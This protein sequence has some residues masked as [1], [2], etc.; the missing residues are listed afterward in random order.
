MPTIDKLYP[1]TKPADDPYTS[2]WLQE[3]IDEFLKKGGKVTLVPPGVCA[4]TP[5]PEFEL[6]RKLE[7]E[8]N[9]GGV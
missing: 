3:K 4:D 9:F 6:R 2:D 1:D 8:K 5:Q 7:K